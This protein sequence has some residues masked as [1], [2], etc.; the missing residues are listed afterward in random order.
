VLEFASFDEGGKSR[1]FCL[2]VLV[3]VHREPTSGLEPLTCSLR[4]SLFTTP[5]PARN[6]RFAGT[7]NSEFSVKYQQISPNIASTADNC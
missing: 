5:N 1:L 6:G 4:V 3:P 2:E 7:C